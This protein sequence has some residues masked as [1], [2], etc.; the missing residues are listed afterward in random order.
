M[1]AQSV[2]VIKIGDV[3][4]VTVPAEP[5][6]TTV[7]EIQEETLT[8]MGKHHAKGLVLDIS[9]VNTMD[10]FFART[11][12]ETASMIAIMGGRTVVVGMRPAVAITT[13]ELGLTLGEA[14]T[15][16]DVDLALKVLAKDAS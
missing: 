3:L 8:A 7:S 9:M 2:S 10:S 16:L 4:Y 14:K 15:A 1:V 6:D 11:L 13:T 5:D 12:A